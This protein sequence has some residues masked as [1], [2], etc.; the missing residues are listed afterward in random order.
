MKNTLK[1]TMSWLKSVFLARKLYKQNVKTELQKKRLNICKTCPYN[2]DNRRY[3]SLKMRV[4]IKLNKLLDWI[5]GIKVTEDA[6]C[7]LCTCNL[8]HK[9]SQEQLKCDIKKW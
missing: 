3:K 6:I 9:T 2:S 1:N 5:M 7:V 8:I 4:G